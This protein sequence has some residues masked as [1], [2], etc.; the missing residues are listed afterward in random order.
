MDEEEGQV[1]IHFDNSF[2]DDLNF[3]VIVLLLVEHF[4][5][6][7]WLPTYFLLLDQKHTFF[8]IFISRHQPRQ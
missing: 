2:L 1:V 3:N 8:V 4:S 6:T 7:F 5:C